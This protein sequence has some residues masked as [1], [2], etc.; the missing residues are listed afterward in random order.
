MTT[1]AIVLHAFPYGE[2]SKIVRLATRD[3][4]VQSAIAKGANRPKSRFGAH[5]QFLSEGVA[6]YHAKPHRELH[7][8]SGFDVTV[9]R[10][11]LAAHLRRYAAA[12]ALAELM[13]RCTPAEPHPEIFDLLSQAL[14]AL[15]AGESAAVEILGLTALWSVVG[16]LGFAPALEQCAG[17]GAS[18]PESGGGAFSLVHGGLLCATCA[19]GVETARLTAADRAALAAFV[20]GAPPAESPDAR[21]LAAHR[22]LLGRFVR[23]HVGEERDLKA[24]TLWETNAG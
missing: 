16:A 23:R 20:A 22:R 19:S 11:E 12:A 15:A 7:T 5:L 17:C 1:G 24:L 4:G 2:T 9:Q 10:H 21:H 3:H 8:L 6:H 18:L 14:D 13:L